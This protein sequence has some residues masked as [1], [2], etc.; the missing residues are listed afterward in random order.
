MEKHTTQPM[1]AQSK[2]AIGAFHSSMETTTV[3]PVIAPISAPGPFARREKTPSANSPPSEPA[4][5]PIMVLNAANADCRSE[6]AIPSAVAGGHA[7]D[8]RDHPLRREEISAIV[9]VRAD[10]AH[11]EVLAP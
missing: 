6:F 4:V 2:P 8:H 5:S 3:K 9:A 1:K 10:D 7:A 11:I